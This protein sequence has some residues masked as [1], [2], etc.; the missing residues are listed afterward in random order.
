MQKQESKREVA[1]PDTDSRKAS[2]VAIAISERVVP[3]TEGHKVEARE[4][5]EE[6]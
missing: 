1:K 3:H 5:S 4:D 2:Q 6:R